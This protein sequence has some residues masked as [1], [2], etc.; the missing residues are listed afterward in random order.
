MNIAEEL[1]AAKKKQM[2]LVSQ[3]NQLEQQKLML[4]Q[5]I[6]RLEGEIRVLERLVEESGGKK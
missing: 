5:E 6:F 4:L 3:I 1:E 2:E